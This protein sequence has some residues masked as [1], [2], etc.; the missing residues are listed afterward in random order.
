MQKAFYFIIFCLSLLGAITTGHHAFAAECLQVRMR[1]SSIQSDSLVISIAFPTALLKSEVVSAAA[2]Y[3]GTPFNNLFATHVEEMAC[4]D[5]SG[6]LIGNIALHE[7]IPAGTASIQY[8]WRNYR[9][10]HFINRIPALSS[11]INRGA[12]A[13]LMPADLIPELASTKDLPIIINLSKPTVCNAYSSRKPSSL[14]FDFVQYA[15]AAYA[16]MMEDPI[17]L[18]VSNNSILNTRKTSSSLLISPEAGSAQ[19]TWTAALGES[20]LHTEVQFPG[21]AAGMQ[22]W[23]LAA[24]DAKTQAA[25]FAVARH[26]RGVNVLF[27]DLND[28]SMQNILNC[29]Q[30][31]VHELL[32]AYAPF[33]FNISENKEELKRLSTINSAGWL[34]EGLCEYYSCLTLLRAHE[35]SVAGF[36]AFVRNRMLQFEQLKK[37]PESSIKTESSEAQHR[38]LSYY[39]KGFLLCLLG[40][41]HL[42]NISHNKVSLLTIL[43][44]FEKER[45]NKSAVPEDLLIPEICKVADPSLYELWKKCDA[46]DRPLPLSN[47]L[48]DAGISY[49]VTTI[50]T[51]ALY[52]DPDYKI[53]YPSGTIE[54]TKVR[55]DHIGLKSGDIIYTIAHERVLPGNMDD[56]LEKLSHTELVNLEAME[57]LRNGQKLKLV[58][59]P[60]MMIR[61]RYQNI[62]PSASADALKRSLRR[63]WLFNH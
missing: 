10:E 7:L 4:Y 9:D 23:I 34:F 47:Y 22:N 52:S 32:H 40:D 51:I 41:I 58:G 27:M 59:K 1:Y 28:V 6:V 19:S 38:Y 44:R 14:Q 50:D 18:T 36:M 20:I 57:V 55:E 3:P 53:L 26:Y 39:S 48:A 46:D 42:L 11:I 31:L 62:Y 45:I 37:V 5:A 43:Q 30:R 35:V 17:L 16:E 13:L 24:P 61:K 21:T 29:K 54:V 60:S 33:R 63:K 56:L 25:M 15:Y 49:D 2:Q 12:D 8:V